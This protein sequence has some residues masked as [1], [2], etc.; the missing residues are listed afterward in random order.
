MGAGH[1]NWY[2]K[3]IMYEAVRK[4]QECIE[5]LGMTL[6]EVSM[7]WLMF[8]S[9]LG[10]GDGVI[11]GGS[12][13]EQIEGNLGDVEKGEV[14]AGGVGDGGGV[15]GDSEGGGAVGLVFKRRCL[16]VCKGAYSLEQQRGPFGQPSHLTTND[17]ASSPSHLFHRNHQS[18]HPLLLPI[19]LTTYT[20]PNSTGTSISGPTVLASAWSLSAPNVATA[21]AM[22]SSK[23]LLAAVKLCVALNRYP[24][25]NLCVTSRVE[26]KTTAK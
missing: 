25:P 13:V 22:A 10:E 12:K 21:T 14:T 15:V 4:L 9:A 3:P 19:S 1:S 7:R 11:V 5:P 24:N 20:N 18:F 17:D 2:D 6:T 8:H 23:L 16:S 26:K